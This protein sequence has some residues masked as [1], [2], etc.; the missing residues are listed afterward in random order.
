[1]RPHGPRRVRIFQRIGANTDEAALLGRCTSDLRQKVFELSEQVLLV[2]EESLHL[3]I[4]LL[5]DI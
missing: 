3:D 4:D 5:G 1:V 2:F